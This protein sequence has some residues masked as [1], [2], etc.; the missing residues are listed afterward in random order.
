M[1]LTMFIKQF[2]TNYPNFIRAHLSAEKPPFAFLLIWLLGMASV[3]D[4]V[5]WKY[6]IGGKYQLDNWGLLWGL[7]LVLGILSGYIR[8]FVGGALYHLRVW[9]SGGLKN[10][11]I[12]RN[13]FLYCG[14]PIY[15][16]TILSQIFNTFFYGDE[17][18]TEPTN[19]LFDILWFGLAVVAIVYSIALSYRGVRLLQYTKCLQSI[20]FFI[21]LP[22]AFYT[23][24][25][26]ATF[27]ESFKQSWTAL[28]H[29][30][31]ALE[32]MSEGEYEEAEVLFNKALDKMTKD[33]RDDII[34]IY[35]NLGVLHEYKADLETAARYYRK[36][37]RISEP[38]TSDYH[39]L[40][41]KIFVIEGKFKKAISS[42]EN[43][44]KLDPDDLDALNGLGLIFLGEA[45][46]EI[47]DYQGALYYNFK[48]YSLSSSEPHMANL[49]INYFL[50]ERY[51]DALPLF[52]QLNN[53]NPNNAT[54]KY[55][56]GLI[57][58]INKDT[59][60]A[61]IF[62][63]EAFALDPSLRISDVQEGLDQ[64]DSV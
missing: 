29:N 63:N 35:C 48:A 31:Q 3:I 13:L 18:F 41:G 61:R 26:G 25:F 39:S 14:L 24:F 43:A 15:L 33:D 10:F 50:L 44:L 5:E 37:L 19:T 47:Q 57:Y 36:A 21:A 62:L 9:L 34:T 22:A 32:L 28:D 46:D 53:M 30:E 27:Y 51:S 56:L 4:R 11:R 60:K 52:E 17:Y 54:A 23:V 45:D 8:Y 16:I 59:T 40:N 38:D 2:F 20:V 1:S 42:F 12:S 55:F 6:V 7:I 58:L 64:D 49:A